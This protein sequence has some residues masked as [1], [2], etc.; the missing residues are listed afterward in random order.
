MIFQAVHD[1]TDDQA[2]GP[3]LTLKRLVSS[4]RDESMRDNA[5]VILLGRGRPI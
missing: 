1:Q 5:F 2:V 3:D 4:G